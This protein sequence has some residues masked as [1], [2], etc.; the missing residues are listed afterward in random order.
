MARNKISFSKNLKKIIWKYRVEIFFFLLIIFISL[1]NLYYVKV[2]LSNKSEDKVVIKKQEEK[3]DVGGQRLIFVDVSGAVVSP[4][5]YTLEEGARIKNAIDIAGGFSKN[6]DVFFFYRN[7]NLA[8]PL[9]DGQKIY[10]PYRWEVS[11]GLIREPIRT[12]D[13][14][15]YREN[16]IDQRLKQP[17]NKTITK[18]ISINNAT[19]SEL[20]SLP[21]I[22]EKTAKRI[23]ENRPYSS[24][25]ELLEKRILRRSV[26]EN[27][28]DSL[29][30]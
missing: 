22:G 24:I 7:F 8:Y 1:V 26:Y 2:E 10:V 27:I 15:G 14:T 13:F 3:E 30:L 4:G 17:E 16:L 29:S 20:E 23:I 5:L 19:A 6:A 12:F 9:Y 25:E 11:R 18:K 28:K 21:G